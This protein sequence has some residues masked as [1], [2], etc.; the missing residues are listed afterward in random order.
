MISAY[1]RIAQGVRAAIARGA[2]QPGDR[3][4]SSRQLAEREGV[5]L[6]TAMQALRVLEAGG[7]IVARPRSGYFVAERRSAEPVRSQ[8][9][10]RP[11]P[12]TIASLARSLFSKHSADDIPLGAALPDPRWLPV[13]D[14]Q[15]ALSRAARRLGE[16]AQSYSTVPGR[17]DLRRQL[18]RRAA[19]W[20][21]RFG[22]D[23]LL[24]TAGE[25][26]AMRLALRVTCR[27][28]DVVAVESPCYF[29]TL[30][31]LESMGLRALELPTD[32]QEGLNVEQL[33]KVL[34]RSRIAAVVSSPTAQN[35]LGATMPIEQKRRLVK[36]LAARDVP[37]IE[38]DV[39]GDLSSSSPRA[40]PC[41]AY[42]ESGIVL[43]CSS[44]SKTLA[45]GWRLGWIAGGRFHAAIV[46]SRF[47]ET[48]AGAPLLE[49][50][51]AEYL[52]SG[53][54]E[55]HLRKFRA[56]VAAAV[57]AV[58]A[59]VEVSFP[60]GTRVGRPQDGFLLWL[61]LPERLNALDIHARALAQG[62]SVS[63][64]Q[65]FSP[66]SRFTHH[67][68]LN[69]ANE[70]TPPFLRAVERIGQIC[71]SALGPATTRSG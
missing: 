61:E 62:I 4:P 49:A 11:Q 66:Q 20:G 54:Y 33:E 48:L 12:V 32:P 59:R 5:S 24:I 15:R 65:I 27:P 69:C 58:A 19:H 39:Y 63:P 45:P 71:A 30:L 1:Q 43:Y 25:T 13:E 3:L 18:A 6:P 16:Q 70:I 64:G 21:A 36:L 46:Q 47:E 57:R 2:W 8:P 52:R 7:Y 55:R 23:D 34:H 17:M 28:G 26:Q 14:L 56:R 42:D 51:L 9:P 60:A 68:R 50:A 67:L 41:K 40:P 37:L 22:P 38:D 44:A 53:D 10:A 31:V 29:G 35:P